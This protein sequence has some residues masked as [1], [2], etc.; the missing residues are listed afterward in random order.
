ML[1]LDKEQAHRLIAGAAYTYKNYIRNQK[2]IVPTIAF[3]DAHGAP[4]QRFYNLLC[5]AYG[6]DQEA[7]AEVVEKG[8]LPENRARS[9]RM[10]Y[11]E[12]DFAFNRLF[13]PTIDPERGKIAMDKRWLPSPNIQLFRSSQDLPAPSSP[14]ETDQPAK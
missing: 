8:Y 4:M 2:V 1:Q 14:S 13:V 6:A 7:F 12:A 5:M 3:A 11:G 10:E 9:C